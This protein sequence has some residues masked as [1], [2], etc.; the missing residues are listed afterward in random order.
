VTPRAASRCKTRHRLGHCIGSGRLRQGLAQQAA[1]GEASRRAADAALTAQTAQSQIGFALTANQR[2]QQHARGQGRATDAAF[3]LQPQVKHMF[4]A[5]QPAQ[6]LGQPGAGDRFQKRGDR[7]AAHIHAQKVAQTHA[8]QPHPTVV[9]G[10]L[11]DQKHLFQG[12]R[13]AARVDIIAPRQAA[14]GAHRLPIGAHV[15]QGLELI[16]PGPQIA[17]LAVIDKPDHCLCP[18]QGGQRPPTR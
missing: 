7:H 1:D 4:A 17:I 14:P 6:G 15:L 18:H 2:Q 16:C 8:G 10:D 11:L 5:K 12:L 13:H 9:G 3:G